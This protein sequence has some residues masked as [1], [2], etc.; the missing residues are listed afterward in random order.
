MLFVFGGQLTNLQ[1]FR[2]LDGIIHL[3]NVLVEDDFDT[4]AEH[5]KGI[6][7]YRKNEIDWNNPPKNPE[8]YLAIRDSL[9]KKCESF[10]EIDA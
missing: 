6:N 8:H 1:E 4:S 5:L 10:I 3:M 9:I 7:F 2:R